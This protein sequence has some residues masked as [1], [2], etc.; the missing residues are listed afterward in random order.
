[1]NKKVN[2]YEKRG[3]DKGVYFLDSLNLKSLSVK[4]DSYDFYTRIIA[5]GKDDLRVVL[6]NFQYSSKIKTYIWK[7][8]RYTDIESLTE[9]AEAKLN[10]LSK[11][12]R[13]YSA[14]VID[15]ANINKEDYEGILNYR[16]CYNPCIKRKW[17]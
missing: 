9:D 7:D 13:A 12:Y 3:S 1:M 14:T 15:L 16:G 2:I 4:S 8:E 5:K 11:P 10:D 17:N 6:E